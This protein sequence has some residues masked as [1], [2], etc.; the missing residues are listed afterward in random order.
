MRLR[1][2]ATL[3]AALLLSGCAT[4]APPPTG[5][6]IAAARGA[7][8]YSAELRVGLRGPEMRGRASV[9]VAFIRPDRLRLEMPGAQ[10]AR[11]VLV[12][13]GDR[14]V[15]AFPEDGAV[16]EGQANADTIAGITGVSLS[17]AGVMDLL[18]GAAPAEARDYRAEWGPSL[19]RRVR[20]TLSDG[21]HLDVK[22]SRP[23]VDRQ[24][25]EA[26]FDP[27]PHSGYRPV[28]APEARRLWLGR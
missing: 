24:V 14:L 3:A 1:A 17:A 23:D 8:S 21:T 25:P 11:F 22:V 13:R 15:A 28:T 12:A 4:V 5:S 19:P 6:I 18:V 9:I 7:G 16:F 27:P 26:A 20:A 10:G 2:Q